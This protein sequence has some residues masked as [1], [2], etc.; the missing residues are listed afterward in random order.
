M[1]E[2]HKLQLI[3]IWND[4][5]DEYWGVKKNNPFFSNVATLMSERGLTYSAHDCK[6][7]MDIM[8]ADFKA[9][10]QSLQRT[11]NGRPRPWR[12]YEHLRPIMEDRVNVTAQQT[13]SVGGVNA[14]TRNPLVVPED[15]P[16]RH[17]RQRPP[18]PSTKADTKSALLQQAIQS[19]NE[20]LGVLQDIASKIPFN[21]PDA[22]N[23]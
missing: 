23:N 11:G 18:P 16:E 12:L 19:R 15:Q 13:F 1:A 17:G 3:E 20:L 4:L 22:N 14:Q 9:Y 5:K 6:Y 8:V 10:T 7:N 2:E 21:K